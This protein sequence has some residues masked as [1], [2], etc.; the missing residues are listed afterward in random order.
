MNAEGMQYKFTNVFFAFLRVREGGKRL[1]GFCAVI[2]FSQGWNTQAVAMQ[3]HA[4]KKKI[5]K[6]D[7]YVGFTLVRNLFMFLFS[8]LVGLSAQK[9]N[10]SIFLH[11]S[12]EI[13][14][15][16]LSKQSKQA[17]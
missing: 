11:A 17:C 7:L 14:E 12:V 10:V 2:V 4:T 5:K 1:W 6:I 13:L 8:M 15:I 3:T 16:T 9:K